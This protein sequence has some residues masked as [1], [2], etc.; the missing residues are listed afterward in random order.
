MQLL[1]NTGKPYVK[2]EYDDW[3]NFQS[4]LRSDGMWDIPLELSEEEIAVL[5]NEAELRG[6]DLND[7]MVE[8]ITDAIEYEKKKASKV[9]GTP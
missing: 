2:V 3:G 6:I 4:G 9:S 1:D 7:L 8:I 5:N